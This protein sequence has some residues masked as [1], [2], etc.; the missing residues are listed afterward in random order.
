MA[1]RRASREAA[2]RWL[3]DSALPQRREGEAAET[4]AAPAGRKTLEA[5]SGAERIA[6]ALAVVASEAERAQVPALH[7]V[8]ALALGIGLHR[9]SAA[10][11]EEHVS[12]DSLTLKKIVGAMYVWHLLGWAFSLSCVLCSRPWCTPCTT[13]QCAP[14][15]PLMRIQLQGKAAGRWRP[16][17]CCWARPRRPIC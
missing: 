6:D 3:Q 14:R 15:R 5:V 7:T 1:A 16:T 8:S 2:V 12:M 10:P 13:G 9:A 4:A 17:R 11:P